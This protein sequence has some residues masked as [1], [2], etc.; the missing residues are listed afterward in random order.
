MDKEAVLVCGYGC[1]LTEEI[2]QYLSA[3]A[4]YL[5]DRPNALVITSGGFTSQKTAPGISEAG[6]MRDYLL[7]LGVTQKILDDE[8]SLTT[9]ENLW[10]VLCLLSELGSVRHADPN[11]PLYFPLDSPTAQLTIF[12]DKIRAYKIGY[13]ARRKFLVRISVKGVDFH[14]GFF[15]AAKQR[16]VATPFEIL[17]FHLPFLQNLKKMT[18]ARTNQAR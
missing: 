14:R 12:C 10:H 18:R 8:E 13:I 15:E 16:L 17:A 6:L 5:K 4:D 9:H 7:S 2:K 3:V 1:H 11:S